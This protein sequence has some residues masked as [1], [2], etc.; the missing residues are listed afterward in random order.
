MNNFF[1]WVENLFNPDKKSKNK[2]AKEEFFYKVKD[3]QP[4]KKTA[5]VTQKR[6]D[7]ILDKINQKGFHFLTEEEKDILKRAANG[8]DL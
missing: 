4:Y 7:E 1:D 3:A 5:N 2:P 8:D 6:V